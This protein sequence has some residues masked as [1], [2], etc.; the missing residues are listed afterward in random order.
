MALGGTKVGFDR[1]NDLQSLSA[2]KMGNCVVTCCLYLQKSQ[3]YL[4]LATIEVTVLLVACSYR[5]HY[6][7]LVTTEVT[8]LSD[9]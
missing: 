5:S 4:L 1:N 2:D 9:R 8:V 6:L 7:L 3:C